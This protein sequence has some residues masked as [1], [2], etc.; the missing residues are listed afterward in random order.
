M[1]IIINGIYGKM[2]KELITVAQKRGFEIA[3]GIDSQ[4]GDVAMGF[5]VYETIRQYE[6]S[7]DV[8]IDFS[9][10][11]AIRSILE[12]CRSKKLP[13]V[14]ATTGF[15]EEEIDYIAQCAQEIPIFKSANMS[16]GVNLQLEL[17]KI[18][19]AFFGERFDI[20]IVEKHHRMK[21][22]APSGTALLLADGISEIFSNDKGYVFGRHG[23]S[24]KRQ[25]EIGI[26]A[27]R[28]GTVVGEHQVLFLGDNEIIEITHKAESRMVFAHGACRAAEFLFGRDPGLYDMHS[29]VSTAK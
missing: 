4:K 7:S 6:G 8:L 14:I 1:K 27:V 15:S 20:E 10:P 18:T 2:G 16:L 21:T 13:A 28:G 12:Y 25:S 11:S 23:R 26:H 5:P 19:A 24:E 3:A 17:A 22:D 29:I 9:R